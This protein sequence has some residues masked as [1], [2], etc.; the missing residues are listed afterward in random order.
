MSKFAHEIQRAFAARASL[1]AAL[2]A[3]IATRV[4]AIAAAMIACLQS[5]GTV[6]A[7]GNGGSATQAAH[8]AA[9]L[10]GRYKKNRRALPAFALAENS[11]VVTSIS[12]DY[13]FDDVFAHQIGGIGRAGDC[14]LALSTSG[15]SRNVVKACRA[16]GEKGLHVFSLTGAGGGEMARLSEI[17][18]AVPSSDT[19]LVQEL[20]L[21]IVHILCQVVEA[22][23]FPAS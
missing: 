6:Y 1:A 5:G 18:V 8:F 16:A 14:L 7:C 11:A 12:N 3:D 4:G 23:M 10:V 9:E 13:S 17:A 22:E 21:A 2:D 20:H 19:P 15:T